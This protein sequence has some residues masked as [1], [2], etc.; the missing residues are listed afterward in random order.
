MITSIKGLGEMRRDVDPRFSDWL[1]SGPVR[2]ELF[3]GKLLL[4]IIET[5]E[6]DLDSSRESIESVVANFLALNVGRRAGITE[7]IYKNY[8]PYIEGVDPSVG[9]AGEW[10]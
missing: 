10:C 2:V 3:E 6:V 4:F 9:Q 1:Y 8:E 5:E 7:L